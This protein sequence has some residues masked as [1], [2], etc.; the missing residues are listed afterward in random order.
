MKI[1]I[2]LLLSIIYQSSFGAGKVFS[3]RDAEGN[4][5][6]GDKAPSSDAKSLELKPATGSDPDGSA[7]FERT[8]KLVDSFA[9]E[10]K[11]RQETREKTSEARKQRKKDC[12]AAKSQFQKVSSAQFLYR[13]E[14]GGDKQILSF[15]Q[16]AEAEEKA[17]AKIR[18]LCGE[19]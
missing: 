2:F 14:E 9:E 17:R 6:F 19:T 15:E 4:L 12:L 5:H 11:E 8:K 1:L 3:W 18:E 10:R 16:R 13:Q 7:R